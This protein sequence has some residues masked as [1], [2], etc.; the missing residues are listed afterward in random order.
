MD[1]AFWTAA[2]VK[3]L[4]VHACGSTDGSAINFDST[5]VKFGEVHGRALR[6][7]VNS[8]DSHPGWLRKFAGAAVAA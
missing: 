1:V 5:E 3:F 2:K 8:V 7:N 6:L 4:A